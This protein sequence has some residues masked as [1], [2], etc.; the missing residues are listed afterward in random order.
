[1]N[2]R[3][4]L[5]AAVAVAGAL[6]VAGT[7][8]FAGGGKKFS[9]TLTGYEEVPAVSSGAAG[10]FRATLTP[11]DAGF[12]YRLEYSGLEGNVT[13]AHVHFGQRDVAGG[14][15]V[16]LCTNLGNGP[17]GTQACPPSPAVVTGTITATDVVGPTAQGIGVGEIGE[18]LKA[19]R[20]RITYANVHS[21]KW[22]GGEVRAQLRPSWPGN[23]H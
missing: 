6:V 19:M 16:F 5:A 13:Q 18:L 20:S 12:T 3:L 9:G 15:S 2:S 11:S 17:A 10:K 8:A 14:I 7:V 4:K 1:M 21:S 22:P 23:D